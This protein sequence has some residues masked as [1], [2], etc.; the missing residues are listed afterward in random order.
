MSSRKGLDLLQWQMI[1]AID[2][3]IL[4]RV[5]DFLVGTPKL[6]F[7]IIS[8][9]GAIEFGRQFP[10]FLAGFHR[11]ARFDSDIFQVLIYREPLAMF[12]SYFASFIG[13][14][15]RDAINNALPSCTDLVPGGAIDV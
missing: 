7:Q 5:A 10:D 6:K 9:V 4:P 14:R 3:G 15:V 12:N 2:T 11:L 13:I 8:G 1:L